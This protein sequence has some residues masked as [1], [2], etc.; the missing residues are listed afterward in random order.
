MDANLLLQLM[1]SM[2]DPSQN[3]GEMQEMH[4]FPTLPPPYDT[5]LMLRPMLH[6]REQRFID[7]LVKMQELKILIAEGQNEI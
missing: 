6:P 7:I 4:E 5:L 2:N 1:Q 3:A